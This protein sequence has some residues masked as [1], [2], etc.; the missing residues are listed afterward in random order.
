MP[1]ANPTAYIGLGSNLADP[2]AQVERALE[3]LARLPRSRVLRSSRLYRSAPWG[4][5]D[6]PEFVNAAA[7]IETVLSPFGQVE[8]AFSR[9]H[10]GT[11][12]GL[13]LA[14]SLAEMHG[15]ALTLQS[16]EGKGTAV[17]VHLPPERVG[18]GALRAAS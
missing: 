2:R 13:P 11:G 7:A 9:R 5:L 17:T 18:T 4:M 14:K 6:Q 8:S 3:R 15:G 12:L 16:T 1:A 10:H